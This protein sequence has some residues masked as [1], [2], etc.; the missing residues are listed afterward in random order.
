[1]IKASLE[2]TSIKVKIVNTASKA[3]RVS[4]GLRQ[5]DA[6]S[7]VLCNLVLEKIVGDLNVLLMELRLVT[8]Q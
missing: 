1:L 5:G 8:R 3:V 6:F 7:P 4:T 2:N